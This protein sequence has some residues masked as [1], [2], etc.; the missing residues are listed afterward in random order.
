MGI[1]EQQQEQLDLI[2]A[3]V[4]DIRRAVEAMQ[5]PAAKGTAAKWVKRDELM[6]RYSLSRNTAQRL[7][8][9]GAR[10][11][12]VQ[13]R[14]FRVRGEMPLQRVDADTFDAFLKSGGCPHTP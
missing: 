14:T 8:D 4:R 1:L 6:K 5:Q 9:D 12:M 3:M 11:G 10:C 2:T 13:V 7:I